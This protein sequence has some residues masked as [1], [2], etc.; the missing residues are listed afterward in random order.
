M[1]FLRLFLRHH[2]AGIPVAG[3]QNVGG[4]PRLVGWTS[5]R[6]KARGNDKRRW[7]K[8]NKRRIMVGREGGGEWRG[9]CGERRIVKGR[10]SDCFR[11]IN[12]GQG[13]L[14]YHYKLMTIYVFLPLFYSEYVKIIDGSGTTVLIRNGYSSTPQKPFAEVSF[15]NSENITV[16]IYLYSSYSTATLQFGILQQGLLSG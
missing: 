13:Y 12:H 14:G 11:R 6:R 10:V 5:R 9:G 16:Q 15:G 4:V 7:N 8:R 3:L 2:F 1:E